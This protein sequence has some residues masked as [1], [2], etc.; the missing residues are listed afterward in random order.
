MSD[1]TPQQTAECIKD[2]LCRDCDDKSS[3]AICKLWQFDKALEYALVMG[4]PPTNAVVKVK[5]SERLLL[6]H[7]NDKYDKT[8]GVPEGVS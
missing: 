6:K 8:Y 4:M 2:Q 7:L 5:E 3:C 1:L